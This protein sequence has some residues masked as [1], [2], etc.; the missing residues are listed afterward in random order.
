MMLDFPTHVFHA[1]SWGT[2]LRNQ[3]APPD[4]AMTFSITTLSIKTFGIM[5]LRKM[6]LFATLSIIDT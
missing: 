3:G 5:T 1:P 2:H 6:G 4:G